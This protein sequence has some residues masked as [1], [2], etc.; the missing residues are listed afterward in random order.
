MSF[1]CS[2][3]L[4]SQGVRIQWQLFPGRCDWSSCTHSCQGTGMLESCRL[5]LPCQGAPQESTKCEV[6]T[7]KQVFKHFCCMGLELCCFLLP[8]PGQRFLLDVSACLGAGSSS[9][10][11]FLSR[12]RICAWFCLSVHVCGFLC[13]LQI[14]R[15][16][17]LQDFFEVLFLKFCFKMKGSSSLFPIFKPWWFYVLF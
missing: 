15:E 6:N 17:W 3:K 9:W 5:L 10:V 14:G 4:L 7:L 8:E 2:I 16:Y 1:I 12:Q 11:C 13:V